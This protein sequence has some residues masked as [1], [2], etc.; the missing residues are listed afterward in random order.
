MSP[1]DYEAVV[2][3]FCDQASPF[4]FTIIE[5]SSRIILPE[6]LVDDHTTRGDL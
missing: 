1:N 6:Q 5:T 3:G 2:G 4:S